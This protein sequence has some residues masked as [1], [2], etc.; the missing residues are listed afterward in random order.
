ME[1]L[2]DES[3]ATRALVFGVLTELLKASELADHFQAFTELIILKVLEAHRDEEKDVERA[4]EAAAGAMA[5]VL[6]AD[7]VIRVL[8]PIIRTGDFP[9]NQAAVKMLTRVCDNPENKPAVFDNLSEIMPGLLKS[10]DNVE[11]SVRKA[12][13]FCMVN[14]HQMVGEELQPHLETLNGSKLKLLNLYIKR[15]QTQKEQSA[16]VSPRQLATPL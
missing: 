7:L 4:A 3:G 5:A 6:P 9:V 2:S 12:S 11:S 10:Y 13:V 8:N 1:N 15:A 14:L 16:P